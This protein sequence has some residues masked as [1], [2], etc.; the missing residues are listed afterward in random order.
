MAENTY[1][2][3]EKLRDEYEDAENVLYKLVEGVFLQLPEHIEEIF[4]AEKAQ[5]FS[6]L[7]I[8]CHT[9]KGILTY[10]FAE[11]GVQLLG[12]LE[13]LAEDKNDQEIKLT[14]PR[15]KN[16]ESELLNELKEHFPDKAPN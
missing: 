11:K 3:L 5:D 9:L 1:I 7:K 8:A 4:A 13:K 6:K 14:M 10:L 15:I 12:T 2:N 16:M